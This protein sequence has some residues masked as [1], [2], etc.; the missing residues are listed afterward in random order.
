LET[1]NQKPQHSYG[2]RI[3]VGLVFLTVGL[4]LFAQRLDI[5][6]FNYWS[7]YI[8]TW[9]GLLI[10]IGLIL[11][12]NRNSRITGLILIAVGGIYLIAETMGFQYTARVFLWPTIFIAIGLMLIFNR[13]SYKHRGHF[14]K[15]VTSM[16]IIDD[17]VMFG[18]NE[19]KNFSKN[20]QGGRLVNIFGGSTYDLSETEL[21]P[22]KQT[23][24]VTSIFGGSKLIIPPSWKVKINV[25]A[26]FGGYAD[27]RKK[28]ITDNGNANGSELIISG[29]VIFGG[30]D[31]KSY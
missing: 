19:Q 2:S 9:Q 10:G 27:K 8:F 7:N 17:M 4:L 30:G 20:F 23:L 18:G 11:M 13:S 21:A 26:I 3:M 22:G 25:V 5:I 1:L 16:D 15:E 31:I 29:I 24:N 12:T 6:P 28:L 14:K